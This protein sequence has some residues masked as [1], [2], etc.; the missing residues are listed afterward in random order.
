MSSIAGFSVEGSLRRFTFRLAVAS[1]AVAIPSTPRKTIT[2]T[3]VCRNAVFIG[4]LLF[5]LV[6]KRAL[7]STDTLVPG[8]KRLNIIRIVIISEI[9]F[10]FVG[11]FP[12]QSVLAERDTE[13]ET[14][15]SQRNIEEA[16]RRVGN[17]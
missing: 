8:G 14:L 6:V 4:S 10:Q 1:R 11:P 13:A 9:S 3:M 2:S 15:L 16:V 12:G 5:S 17:S 7:R